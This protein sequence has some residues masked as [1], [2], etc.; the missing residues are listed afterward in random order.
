M[1]IQDVPNPI[2]VPTFAWSNILLE[3]VE[4]GQ[5]QTLALSKASSSF[6][7]SLDRSPGCK[8]IIYI[9]ELGESYL[10]TASQSCEDVLDHGS[11]PDE[12]KE[13]V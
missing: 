1:T 6:L 10:R 13:A 5:H 9:L 11:S 4:S 3:M 2:Q 12:E 8:E 7:L